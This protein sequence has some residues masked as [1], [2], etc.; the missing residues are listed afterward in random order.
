MC[1]WSCIRRVTLSCMEQSVSDSSREFPLADVGAYGDYTPRSVSV[2][3]HSSSAVPRCWS[4][5]ILF[6]ISSADNHDYT[7]TLLHPFSLCVRSVVT[8][9]FVV[10]CATRP[11]TFR[12]PDSSMDLFYSSLLIL[13]VT[14]L[15][16]FMYLRT[17][18]L[19]ST[20]SR[21]HFV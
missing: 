7:T 11:S 5:C 15:Y 17:D 13:S 8:C 18:H 10:Y 14:L 12:L 20:I 1:F 6:D 21:N 9:Y 19:Q 2:Y 16:N 4:G 3:I